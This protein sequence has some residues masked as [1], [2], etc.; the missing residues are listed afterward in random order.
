M[1]TIGGARVLKGD[2]GRTNAHHGAT[3]IRCINIYTLHWHWRE[4]KCV[5]A[6]EQSDG[7][8]GEDRARGVAH[9]N[10][11]GNRAAVA[12]IIGRPPGGQYGVGS[13]A[14]TILINPIT[15]N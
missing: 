14:N 15:N 4:R 9:K 6:H 5:A 7:N 8:E 13:V 2:R 11:L 1:A 3:Q 12:A 10:I